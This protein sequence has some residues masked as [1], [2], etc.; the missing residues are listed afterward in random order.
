MSSVGGCDQPCSLP[1]TA[2]AVVVGGG[3][4]GAWCAWFLKRRPVWPRRAPRA[5]HPRQGRQLAGGRHGP[6]PGRHRGRGPARPV[7]PRLLLLA[8]TTCSAS[9]P[10]SSPRAT[11]CRASPT[12]RWPRPQARIA[13]QQERRARRALGASRRVRRH[14][15]RDG[16]RHDA[17]RA[18]T[19]PA[20]A[21]STRRATC[22]PTPRPCSPPASRSSSTPRS[23]G[24]TA[25]TATGHRRRPR[26]TARSPPSGSC[27]PAG[28]PWPRSAGGRRTDPGRRC[29]PPGRR[30]RGPPRPRR[31][32]AADGLRPRVRH[33]LAARGGRR[34]CGG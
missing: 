10:A 34:A 26:P 25:S 12:T 15:P 24:L 4:I 14:E 1:R 16:A 5:A 17:G 20:T 22:S 3:T 29:P 2:D 9:T 8:S 31:R 30:H 21:T 28:R 27:S 23:P 13:M 32:P 7:Q 33:L 18:R 19:P 11:S 6:R